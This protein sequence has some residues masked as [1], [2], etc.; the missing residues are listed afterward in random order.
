MGRTILKLSYLVAKSPWICKHIHKVE[1]TLSLCTAGVAV[2]FQK[3]N[4]KSPSGVQVQLS[5][6]ALI[7]A[8]ESVSS[9]NGACFILV[10]WI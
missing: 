9:T 4:F 5:F 1:G 3:K 7:I 2:L 6:P 10:W 8:A